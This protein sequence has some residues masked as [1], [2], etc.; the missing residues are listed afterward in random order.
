MV[1]VFTHMFPGRIM[2]SG[3]CPTNHG[4]DKWFSNLPHISLV[5]KS[6]CTSTDRRWGLGCN[7]LSSALKREII[8]GR[9]K[10]SRQIH[11]IHPPLTDLEEEF[12]AQENASFSSLIPLQLESFENNSRVYHTW[13]YSCQGWQLFPGST[14][15]PLV[16]LIIITLGSA[17]SCIRCR[18]LVI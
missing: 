17:G 15:S 9:F 7:C 12:W 10:I 11:Y 14:L 2:N 4:I 3:L 18:F 16:Y 6:E 5:I 8:D 13:K 1:T